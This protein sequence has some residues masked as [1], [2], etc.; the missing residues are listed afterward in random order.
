MRSRRTVAAATHRSAWQNSAAPGHVPGFVVP[1]RLIELYERPRK[2]V[3][4]I[5]TVCPRDLVSELVKLIRHHQTKCG[6]GH[7][8]ALWDGHGAF[9]DVAAVIQAEADRRLEARGACT[10]EPNLRPEPAASPPTRSHRGSP[11][12]RRTDT[13]ISSAI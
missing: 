12:V 2:G 10:A 5:L 11:G 13:I 4:Q 1:N 3:Q 7:R 9:G 8:D 6:L